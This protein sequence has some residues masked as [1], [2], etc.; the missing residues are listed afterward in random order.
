MGME[1]SQRYSGKSPK[2]LTE[3]KQKD[4]PRG[5]EGRENIGLT[6]YKSKNKE[7][8]KKR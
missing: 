5:R 8:V 6:I 4:E 1:Q 2:T 3:Q 7:N